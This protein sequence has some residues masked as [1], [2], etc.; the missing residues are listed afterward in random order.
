M[1]WTVEILRKYRTIAV[2]GCSRDPSKDARQIPRYMKENGYR[3]IPVNPLAEEVLGERCYKTLLDMPEDV[4]KMVEIVDIFR[5]SED[6]P[7]I[8]DQAIE[9][10]RRVGRPMVV[11]TQLGI[12]NDM[13]AEWARKAGLDVVM[14]RCLMIEH[15]RMTGK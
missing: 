8:V 1:E 9:M 5:P 10:K 13:A 3:I 12:V 4:Q 6:V 7:A 15:K 14:N 11:W 2:V